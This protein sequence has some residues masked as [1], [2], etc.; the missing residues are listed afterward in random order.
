MVVRVGINRSAKSREEALAKAEEKRTLKGHPGSKT[1]DL[2]TVLVKPNDISA[3]P[4][5]FQPREFTFGLREHDR[6]HVKS[7]QHEIAI[8]GELDPPL[9]IKLKRD[10]WVVAEGHHR[11]EAY[12]AAGQGDK[13]IT[14]EWFYGT[15]RE[16]ADAGLKHNNIVKLNIKSA[17]KSE[18]AWKRVVLGW[19]SKREIVK[20]CSVSEGL[21]A[22]MRRAVRTVQAQDEEGE[23]FRK[24]L[25]EGFYGTP[26]K[27]GATAAEALEHLKTLTWGI[28]GGLYRGV[29]KEQFD[30]DAAVMRLARTIQNRLADELS[31]DPKITA[32]ALELYDASLPEALM[33]AWGRPMPDPYAPVVET[34][35]DE[36]L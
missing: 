8:H 6:I 4:A 32:R 16:A 5:I 25:C 15:V 9:V 28:A 33:E 23:A 24:R 27:E 1:G 35:H 26:L 13:E 10:G 7:L 14:C 17:D 22:T 11:V 2:A 12:K 19:G 21:V 18:E 36:D 34:T 30:T 29:T 3:I 20:L 31:K